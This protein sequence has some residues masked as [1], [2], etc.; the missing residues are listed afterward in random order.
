VEGA[1]EE[2]ILG[3]ES[4]AL[5]YS[6]KVLG[7]RHVGCCLWE[8]ALIVCCTVLEDPK[9]RRSEIVYDL[10]LVVVILNHSVKDNSPDK[11]GALK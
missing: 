10:N 9:M 5:V 3:F 1:S 6:K 7:V 8:L 4:L 11:K 2:W